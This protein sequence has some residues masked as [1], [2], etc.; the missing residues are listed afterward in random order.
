MKDTTIPGTD[1]VGQGQDLTVPGEQ[2]R[3]HG[4]SKQSPIRYPQLLHVGQHEV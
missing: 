1:F 3:K 2:K 4:I